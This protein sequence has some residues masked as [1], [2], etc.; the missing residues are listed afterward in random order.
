[1][2][3]GNFKVENLL[4][5]KKF[6]EIFRVWISFLIDLVEMLKKIIIKNYISR[7]IL[8]D[9]IIGKWLKF[10]SIL[11]RKWLLFWAV[12]IFFH[13]VIQSHNSIFIRKQSYN[14][15]IIHIRFLLHTLD[16]DVQCAFIECIQCIQCVEQFEL[17]TI[18][19][20]KRGGCATRKQL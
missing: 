3:S 5:N 7:W 18:D 19:L 16:D 14:V 1:M 2:N 10:Q 9:E 8:N 4:S 20:R 15:Y 12:R 6:S 17:K 11:V 13:N